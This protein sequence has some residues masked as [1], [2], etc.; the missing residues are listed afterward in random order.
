MDP[1][2][3]KNARIIEPTLEALSKQFGTE[4]LKVERLPLPELE[5]R[6]SEG[7]IDVFISTSGLSRRMSQKGSKELVTMVS[8]RLPNPNKAY[9]TLFI[10]R[11]DSDIKSVADMEGK[12]LTTN[13]KGGF[14]GHQIGLGELARRGY[15]PDSFFKSTS[16][17]GRDL[18][19]VVDAVISGK[20]QVG[21]IS[22]CF[23]ED[24]YPK[25]DQVWK[26]IRPIGVRKNK[27][28]CLSSTDLYPN[29]SVSTM[30]STSPEIAK[31]VTLSLLNM[32]KIAGGLGWS[33]A[34]DSQMTDELFRELKV[35]PFGFLKDW[36]N[37]EFK[38]RYTV[39]IFFGLLLL[40]FFVFTSFVLGQLVKIKTRSL[41]I[42]LETQKNLRK[43]AQ[44]ATERLNTMEKLGIVDQLSSVVVHELRQPIATMKAFLFGVR[45]KSEKGTLNCE[46]MMRVLPK[47][48][49][50]LERAEDIVE[51]VRN[52][53]KQRQ[54]DYE[55]IDL[56]KLVQTS[57]QNFLDTG[58]FRGKIKSELESNVIIRGS[59][60]ELELVLNNL[61]KNASEALSLKK[62]R[63]S[64]ISLTLSSKDGNAILEVR[65][66]GG[67]MPDSEVSAQPLKSAKKDGLGLG[68]QIVKTIMLKH[69]GRFSIDIAEDGAVV[70]LTF[71]LLSAS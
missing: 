50:Q 71:P 69:N 33:V 18:R 64:L 15:D 60:L 34:T 3:G 43:K 7:S 10:T 58:S 9:G 23:L 37:R 66:N 25:D 53:A 61:L 5:K 14:Y 13:F 32:P 20:S 4:N 45:R 27:T 47:I 24:E 52:Y 55:E 21:S 39:W 59:R 56:K 17:V 46:D 40:L 57:V 67:G 22:S 62:R 65:D 30:P 38:N 29:W 51:K 6:L 12:T 41:S 68:L 8:D 31:K 36:F 28:S 26:Q 70:V 19:K 44:L 2:Q 16:Y 49:K 11:S 54:S 48:S 42:S 35:G 63:N 1:P